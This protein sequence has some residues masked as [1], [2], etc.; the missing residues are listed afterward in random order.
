MRSE[1]LSVWFN[2]VSPLPRMGAWHIV[3]RIILSRAG[4]RGLSG[5]GSRNKGVRHGERV[6]GKPNSRGLECRVDL[7]ASLGHYR[8]AGR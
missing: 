3:G 7:T 6:A 5:A 4:G 2:A 8:E 1:V